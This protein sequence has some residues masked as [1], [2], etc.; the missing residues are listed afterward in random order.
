MAAIGRRGAQGREADRRREL[1]DQI[2]K[3]CDRVSMV[4][5]GVTWTVNAG[6]A[7]SRELFAV[8]HYQERE[9]AAVDRWLNSEQR[10]GRYVIDIGA[11]I[12]TT[13][14]PFARLGRSVIA[15][16]PVP[17][18]LALLRQNIAANGL[19]PRIVVIPAAVS[20][21]VGEVHMALDG[22][23]GHSEV[24]TQD[25]AA[26]FGSDVRRTLK[27]PAAP[28]GVLLDE[29]SIGVGDV[30]LVWSDTQGHEAE[31]LASGTEL[32]GRGIPC[33]VEV[34]PRGLRCHDALEPFQELAEAWFSSFVTRETLL[35]ADHGPRRMPIR[36]LPGVIE[37]LDEL[38][39]GRYGRYSDVLLIP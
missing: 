13:S 12:G 1:W 36:E 25:G 9:I 18:A 5:D 32:W 2:A 35:E 28:L 20:A 26:G 29:A 31:V 34:W 27:V 30:A 11:N 39:A 15:I 16:E 8:G 6:D 21:V 19:E 23:L 37:R 17:D 7:V 38:P 22:D 24:L 14:I 10:P 33:F 4:R 3:E